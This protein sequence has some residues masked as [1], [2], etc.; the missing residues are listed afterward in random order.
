MASASG[1]AALSPLDQGHVGDAGRA[2][3]RR[4]VR[5]QLGMDLGAGHVAGAPREQGGEIARARANL[6]DVF[7][8]LDRELLDDARLDLG[9]H[10]RLAVA[11]RQ[12]EVGKGERT[13]LLGHEV[14]AL[15]LEQ[16]LEHA[17]VQHLPGADLLLDHVE[18]RLLDVHAR[19][20]VS[21]KGEL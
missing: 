10:H 16:Q 12:L 1:R 21:G 11:E 6:V 17:R 18:A 3:G 7:L 4:R 5:F 19:D 13:V 2:Q 20:A 14:L 8:L 9:L 15:H